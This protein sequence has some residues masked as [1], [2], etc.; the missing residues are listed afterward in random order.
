MVT[1]GAT[2]TVYIP[3]IHPARVH[4]YPAYPALPNKKEEHEGVCVIHGT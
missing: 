1:G 3:H 2:G 4:L